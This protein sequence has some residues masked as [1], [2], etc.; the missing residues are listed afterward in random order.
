MFTAAKSNPEIW[1]KTGGQREQQVPFKLD[2]VSSNNV[3][4]SNLVAG[5]IKQFYE[6]WK[7][8]T[9]NH[10]VLS[11]IQYGFKINFIEKPKCQNVPK[12]P[13]YMLET[14]IITQEVK[15][16]LSKGVII[17]C[18]SKTGDF[19]S[20]VFN[21]QKKDGTFRTI[22]NSKYLNEFVQYQHFKMKSLLD[23]KRY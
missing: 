3:V 15:K 6:N 4:Q 10:I 23:G 1:N 7:K 19:A 21:R 12:I 20:T 13:Y 2:K 16:L 17:E 8:I 18:S 22:L 14:E 5:N 9:N 11:L